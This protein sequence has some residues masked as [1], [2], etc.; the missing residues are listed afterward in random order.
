M[1]H[2]NFTPISN[3]GLPSNM[4]FGLGS[5][6]E[7]QA[8]FVIDNIRWCIFTVTGAAWYLI[9]QEK[10]DGI[11]FEIWTKQFGKNKQEVVNYAKIDMKPHGFELVQKLLRN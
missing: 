11:W 5:E 10:E 9:K 1:E 6:I 7:N 2:L 8:E 3:I 4:N